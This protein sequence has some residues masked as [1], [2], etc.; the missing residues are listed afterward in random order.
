MKDQNNLSKDTMWKATISCDPAYDGIFF[1]AVKTTGIYCRPSCKSRVPN[2]ENASFFSYAEEAKRA[3][4]RPCKRCRPDLNCINYDPFDFIL[5]D[6]MLLIKNNYDQNMSLHDIASSVGVSR[7]H[8]NRIFKERTGC[9]PRIYLEKIR[10]RKAKELLL[11]T[12]FN[13]TEIGYKIGYQS[14]SSFYNAFKKN[15]GFSPTQFRVCHAE[16]I[17]NQE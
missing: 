8:L 15:T 13:S 9:T 4:Y 12:N 6:T 11:I 1:Y 16:N 7:F 17:V 10:V 14:I 3:G 5:E 2:E